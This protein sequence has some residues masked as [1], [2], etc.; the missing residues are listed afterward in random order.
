MH[1]V[2]TALHPGPPSPRHLTSCSQG[3]QVAQEPWGFACC[4]P[5]VTMVSRPQ[6]VTR[7]MGCPRGY[8]HSTG[9]G[10]GMGM[11]ATGPVVWVRNGVCH[12][13]V[14]R[15]EGGQPQRLRA[16]PWGPL[17]SLPLPCLTRLPCTNGH[18]QGSL[19]HVGYHAAKGTGSCWK[20]RASAR[21]RNV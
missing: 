2:L 14:P 13:G 17:L 6:Q 21:D 1:A 3:K 16:G 15:V 4:N 9:T 7:G 20:E 19:S 5:S 8:K 10:M 12:L 18:Q 11:E